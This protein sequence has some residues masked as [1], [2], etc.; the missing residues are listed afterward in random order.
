MVNNEKVRVGYVI[1]ICWKKRKELFM[2]ILSLAFRLEGSPKCGSQ[3]PF[4]STFYYV[5]TSKLVKSKLT[6]LAFFVVEVP[7]R[8][9]YQNFSYVPCILLSSFIYFFNL[10]EIISHVCCCELS[11]QSLHAREIMKL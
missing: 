11:Y 7:I 3:G 8:H 5:H 1:H 2:V 10:V 6:L 4:F 9:T